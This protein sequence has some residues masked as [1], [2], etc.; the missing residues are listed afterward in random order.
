[1]PEDG[2]VQVIDSV[3]TGKGN[4]WCVRAR[5]VPVRTRGVSLSWFALPRC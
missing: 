3:A 4:F 2:V 1:M 5:G